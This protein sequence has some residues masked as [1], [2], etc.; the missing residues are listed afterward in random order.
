VQSNRWCFLTCG[1]DDTER[2]S[3]Q[4]IAFMYRRNGSA[5]VSSTSFRLSRRCLLRARR[6]RPSRRA[7]EKGDELA[8]SH[9]ITSS[10]SVSNVGAT[11]MPSGLAVCR[12]IT[13]S[14]VVGCVTGRS[15]G[16]S[17]LRMRPV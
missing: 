5:K 9:S 7:A 17:P 3:S 2:P 11:A 4:P 1:F 10:A 13:N 16:F 15:A 14:K 12:L 6:E 8:A